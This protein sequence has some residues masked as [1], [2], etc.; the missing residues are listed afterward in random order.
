MD[1]GGG[2]GAGVLGCG[3]C[4]CFGGDDSEG[5]LLL[6]GS[7]LE[8]RLVVSYHVCYGG[9]WCNVGGCC[10]RLVDYHK[11]FVSSITMTGVGVVY[12]ESE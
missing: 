4:G 1:S 8:L 6:D 10:C 9:C 7:G 12:V 11:M 3:G 2:W 5:L